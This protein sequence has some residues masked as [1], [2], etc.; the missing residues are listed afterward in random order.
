M[1]VIILAFDQGGRGSCRLRRCFARRWLGN[2]RKSEEIVS[3]KFD[4]STSKSTL[5]R[6]RGI[7]R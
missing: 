6:V 3:K 1:R 7:A 4:R 2:I 5:L